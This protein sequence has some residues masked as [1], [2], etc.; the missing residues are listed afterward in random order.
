MPLPI[1]RWIARA[2]GGDIRV[3]TGSRFIVDLPSSPI[4]D[5]AG[6]F[7]CAAPGRGVGIDVGARASL[8]GRVK[9]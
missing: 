7:V 2:H 1:C 9:I 4:V 8:S 6:R 3:A 5:A